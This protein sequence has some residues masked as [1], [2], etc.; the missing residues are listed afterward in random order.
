M[1]ILLQQQLNRVSLWMTF[2]QTQQGKIFIAHFIVFWMS[3]CYQKGF[4]YTII[5]W[6]NR[7]FWYVLNLSNVDTFDNY[8][9]IKTNLS[10]FGWLQSGADVSYL[11]RIFWKIVYPNLESFKI[12]AIFKN[13]RFSQYY[14]PENYFF[15]VTSVVVNIGVFYWFD[16]VWHCTN[17]VRCVLKIYFLCDKSRGFASIS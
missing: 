11:Y 17:K 15:I 1:C 6:P 13:I 14:W 4:L 7:R 8:K 12:L 16:L 10:L 5:F 3:F 2:D 9:R